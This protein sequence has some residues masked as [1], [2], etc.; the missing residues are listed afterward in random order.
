MHFFYIKS[1][2]LPALTGFVIIWKVAGFFACAAEA[3]E[4]I[5]GTTNSGCVPSNS[6]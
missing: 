2:N 4:K 1:L 6:S 3:S 5:E